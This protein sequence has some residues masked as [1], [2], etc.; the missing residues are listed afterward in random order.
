[1]TISSTASL[2]ITGWC[3]CSVGP[4]YQTTASRLG[5]SARCRCSSL[6]IPHP[7]PP[8]ISAPPCPQAGYRC[9]P[10]AGRPVL[11]QPLRL[12]PPSSQVTS[13][14]PVSKVV[15]NFDGDAPMGVP[16]TRTSVLGQ[17]LLKIT[18]FYPPYMWNELFIP[19][20]F[21]FVR[22]RQY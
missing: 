18:S 17:D 13:L 16:R 1:V 7:P 21:N 10:H 4:R 5:G 2:A 3:H 9:F 19:V 14:A 11:C 22:S 12:R 20:R 6:S 15:S 8:P